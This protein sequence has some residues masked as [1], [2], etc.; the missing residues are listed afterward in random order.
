[1]PKMPQ[2]KKALP[3]GVHTLLALEVETVRGKYG[4]QEEV[5]CMLE[6]DPAV[7]TRVWVSHKNLQ[8]VRQA[9][10]AG[11]VVID[12]ENQSWEV[13]V[14]ARFQVFIAGGNVVGVSKAPDAPLPKAAQ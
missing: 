6:S 2:E 14:G 11:L 5:T 4:E 9:A 10:A 7:L 1:M 3:N 13:V 8:Q 12:E